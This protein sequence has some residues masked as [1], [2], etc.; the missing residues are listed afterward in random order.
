MQYQLYGDGIHDDYPAIQ[1]M[2]D[3]GTCEVTLPVP[4]VCYRLSKTLTLPS[5]FRLVLPRYAKIRLMDGA[6]CFMLANKTVE[7]YSLKTDNLSHEMF[8]FYDAYSNE[9]EDTAQN[10]EVTGGIWDFNNLGQNQNPSVTGKFEP[11]HYTGFGML[12]YNVKGLKLSNLTLKDPVTFSVTLD[13]VSYFT[14]ENITFDYN[15]GNPKAVS[16]DGIH[17]AGNCHYGVLRNLKGACYDDLVALNAD[18]GSNGPITNIEINGIF[19]ED[20]HSAGRLLTVL[21][22][23]R[24]SPFLMCSGHIISLP[25]DSHGSA[26]TTATAISMLSLWIRSMYP[27]QCAIPF[28]AKTTHVYVPSSISSRAY[29]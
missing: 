27:R 29:A 25:L 19:A 9:P 16:M 18:E 14:V 21:H 12:F 3:S 10:I 4:R 23:W 17:L 13:T 28:T 24:R 2:I 15:Y 11:A 20:C 1:E 26:T 7:K 5:N 8:W 22:L 6:N